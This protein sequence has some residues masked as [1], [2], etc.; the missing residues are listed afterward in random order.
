VVLLMNVLIAVV[1][2]WREHSEAGMAPVL[3]LGVS[4]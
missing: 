2:R 1:R 4:V 3:P